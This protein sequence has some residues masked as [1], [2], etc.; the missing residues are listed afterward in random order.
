MPDCGPFEGSFDLDPTSFDDSVCLIRRLLVDAWPFARQTGRTGGRS[1]RIID[2]EHRRT[3][4]DVDVVTIDTRIAEWIRCTDV[5]SSALDAALQLAQQ[6]MFSGSGRDEVKRM[7]R[8]ALADPI[9]PSNPLF[10]THRVPG[11]F[12]VDDGSAEA[13]QVEPFTSGV[14]GQE[15]RRFTICERV[16]RRCAFLS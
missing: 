11:Q 8:P 15:N 7:Y 16:K 10:Q 14:R 3:L 12:E 5:C 1:P 4:I 13:L 2:G 9:D 6:S